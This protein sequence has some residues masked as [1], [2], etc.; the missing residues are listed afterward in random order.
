MHI[1]LML[2]VSRSAGL[3]EHTLLICKTAEPTLEN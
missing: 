2:L 3:K 1:F